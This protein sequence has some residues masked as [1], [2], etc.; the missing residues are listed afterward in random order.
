M[1]QCGIVSCIVLFAM[2]IL[3]ECDYRYMCTFRKRDA[4][5]GLFLFF[6]EEEHSAVVES[7]ESGR[8]AWRC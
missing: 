5:K 7:P 4:V 6:G 2:Y 8:G 1:A 3:T